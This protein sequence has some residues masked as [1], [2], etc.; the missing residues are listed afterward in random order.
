MGKLRV[1]VVGAAGTWGRYYLGAYAAHPDVDIVALV[2]TA[3]RVAELGERFGVAV[4]G[5]VEE[6][7]AV[8][9]P[10][11]VSAV[12]PVSYNFPIV[13][14]CAEAGVRVVSCEK[15]SPT[16]PIHWISPRQLTTRPCCSR[17][18]SRWRRRTAS[19]SSAAPRAASLAAPS[20]SARCEPRDPRF[21]APVAPTPR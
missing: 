1:A 7:L 19:S 15:A 2:D 11:I 10:D 17:S 14:A 18:T 5:T 8:T 6:L 9:V 12:V 13:A 16:P 3:E 20:V 21:P 4:Y